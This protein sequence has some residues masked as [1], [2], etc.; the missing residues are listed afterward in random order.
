MIVAAVALT[1]C[2]QPP[3]APDGTILSRLPPG[4]PGAA[5]PVATTPP[6]D[7]DEQARRYNQ[8]DR[9]A[10]KDSESAIR[11]DETARALAAQSSVSLG[12]GYGGYG[13]G[14]PAYYGPGWYGGWYGGGWYGRG[15]YGRG[16]GGP[17]SG[18]FIG[19]SWGW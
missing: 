16:W 2:A 11:A 15:G 6:P 1:A 4:A 14:G 5:A 17:R 19:Q 13:W 18:V 9:Q 10:L 7:A 3:I 8:I 12:Y